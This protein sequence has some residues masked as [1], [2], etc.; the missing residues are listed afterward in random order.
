M[1]AAELHEAFNALGVTQ[2]RIAE[3]F[4]VGPRSFRRWVH[5]ERRVPRGVGIV[6]RLLAAGVVTINQVEKAIAS[7]PAV[8]TNGSAKLA[9]RRVTPAP[10]TPIAPAATTAEKVF[11]LAPN[12]C[13]FPCGDPRRADFHFCGRPI[14]REFY[15]EQHVAMAYLAR[16]GHDAV[17]QLTA[18]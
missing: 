3:L 17:R 16:G 4:G 8:R 2:T 15:C 13:R 5:G 1:H 12:A 14:A 6:L 9:P 11:A 18:A 10:E 7:V